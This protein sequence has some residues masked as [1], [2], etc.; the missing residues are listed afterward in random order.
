MYY[1]DEDMTIL[2]VYDINAPIGLLKN[3]L[4]I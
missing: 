3:I 1:D 4:R 2:E